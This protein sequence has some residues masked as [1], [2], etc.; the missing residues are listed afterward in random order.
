MT[1]WSVFI[2]DIYAEAEREERRF[3]NDMVVKALRNRHCVKALESRSVVT[4]CPRCGKNLNVL[5]L[6][7]GQFSWRCVTPGCIAWPEE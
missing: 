3:Y 1:G 6:L 2:R 4:T 7:N 5:F